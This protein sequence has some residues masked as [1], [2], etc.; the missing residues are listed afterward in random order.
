MISKWEC[1]KCLKLNNMSDSCSSCRRTIEDY[2][3]EDFTQILREVEV[4]AVEVEVN[5]EPE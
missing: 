1:W 3:G 4:G 2:T 5:K